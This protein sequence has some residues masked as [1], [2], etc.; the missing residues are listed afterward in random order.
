LLAFTLSAC[1]SHPPARKD[2]LVFLQDGST[3][4]DEVKTR[5]GSALTWAGGDLWTYRIG[6]AADGL[7]L[8]PKKTDWTDARYSLVLEFDYNGVLRRHALINIEK[9]P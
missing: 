2:L 3:T 7:Y 1:A 4:K 6:E 9:Q 8:S 5:I